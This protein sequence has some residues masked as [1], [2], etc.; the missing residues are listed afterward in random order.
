ML[1]SAQ[2]WTIGAAA[3]SLV[4][5]AGG[6]SAQE[7]RPTR[8]EPKPTTGEQETSRDAWLEKQVET[9]FEKDATLKSQG[10]D[11]TVVGS[12]VT[13]TGTTGSEKEKRAAQR[14]AETVEGVSDVDNQIMVRGSAEAAKPAGDRG[15]RA[16]PR[17]TRSES[18][19]RPAPQD[20]PAVPS[21]TDP[22]RNPG[23]PSPTGTTTDPTMPGPAG[24]DTGPR[25]Q[26][27]VRDD[28]GT[29]SPAD[30]VPPGPTTTPRTSAPPSRTGTDTGTRRS[31]GTPPYPADRPTPGTTTP[32]P[33]DR[34][35]PGTTTNPAR[36][37][38]PGTNQPTPPS[39]TDTGTRGQSGTEGTAGETGTAGTPVKPTDS[40]VGRKPFEQPGTREQRMRNLGM[41][42]PGKAPPTSG[43]QSGRDKP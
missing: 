4:L 18:P 7:P 20:Q 5:S 42:E 34:P 14:L 25:G 19:A 16:K 43:D 29:R 30:L 10:L 41:P 6:A 21:P 15:K 36:P 27:G 24:T 28:L 12:K 8:D 33:A 40:E 26:T 22:A 31:T 13:L 3:L 39:A 9:R 11:A 1:K 2:G 37:N 17:K 35:A 23:V 38:A 32:G